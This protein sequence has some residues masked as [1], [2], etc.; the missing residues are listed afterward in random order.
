MVLEAIGQIAVAG[1][2]AAR[3]PFRGRLLVHSGVLAALVL[4]YFVLH[5]SENPQSVLTIVRAALERGQ[6]APQSALAPLE[7][8]L[9]PASICIGIAATLQSRSYGPIHTAMALMVLSRG[10]GDVPF[11]ALMIM[12]ATTWT[13]VS[14]GTRDVTEE[15]IATGSL[16]APSEG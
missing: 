3:A 15:R 12:T 6:T 10:R 4:T 7:M 14:T 8:F 16:H 13:L 2:A 9:T 5:A 1:W 11:G